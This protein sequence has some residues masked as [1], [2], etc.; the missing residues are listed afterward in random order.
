MRRKIVFLPYDMDT[1]LGINNEGALAFSYD[2]EDI[3]HTESGADIFNGQESVLWKNMRACYFDEMRSMYQ[4]L[5][6]TGALSY[7]RVEQMF[8]EH[9]EKWPEAVFNEDA[10]FKYL[11]PLVEKGNAAYL[12]MLQGSK[13]SQRRWWLYNRFRYIDS[14]YN[15]GDSL[16]D[17]IVIRGYAKADITVTPYA[18]VYASVKYG[19]YLI[20]ERAARNEATTLVCPLDNVNDTEIMIFSASQL[21]DV[22]DL[23]GLKVGYADF[24]RATRLQYLKLGDS[25]DEYTNGNLI[26][27]YL[28]NN[29]LLRTIDVR[30]CPALTQAV[31]LSGCSNIEH[32][33]FGG[34]SV[35]GL[36]LP[37]GGIL[38]TLQLPSTVT[39]L[40]ILNQPSLTS[41]SIG[42]YDNISTLRL[43]NVGSGV[44]TKTILMAL[45]ANSRVR[46]IDFAWE[47]ANTAEIESI[48]DK[49][50][51]MRGLDNNGN[52]VD[53]AQVY[54]TIH[55]SS[56]AGSDLDALSARYP[57]ITITADEVYA[58]LTYKTYDGS[59]IIATQTFTNGGNGTLVNSRL[60]DNSADGHYRYVPNGW[61]LTPDGSADEDALID[62]TAD[63]TVYAAY[64]AYVMLYTVTWVDYD[65][66]VL[67]TDT[68]VPWGTVP[69]YDGDIP[70]HENEIFKEWT[71]E[72]SAITG[73]TTYTASYVTKYTITFVTSSS[74]GGVTFQTLQV[75][76]GDTPVYTGETPT[77][78]RGGASEYEF[79]GWTPAITAATENATYTAL[80]RDIRSLTVK[81]LAKSLTEYNS[82]SNDTLASYGLYKQTNLVSV[83]VPATVINAN[84]FTDSNNIEEVD[85]TST[86]AIT[87]PASL[88]SGKTKLESLIIRSTTMSTL[89]NVNAFT[90][91]K[92][93]NIEG[94]IYV[95]SDLV[96]TYKA[97]T[98]WS[99]FVIAPIDSYPADISTLLPTTWE[100]INT[101][102][103]NGD[104]TSWP[105]GMTVPLT[106]GNYTLTMQLVAKDTD[107]L[108]DGSGNAHTTWI[109]KDVVCSSVMN[110]SSSDSYGYSSTPLYINTL[111]SLKA[112]IDS[113]VQGYMKS[114]KK[115]WRDNTSS[116]TITS[117]ETFWIPSCREMY[118]TGNYENTGCV[119]TSFFTNNNSRIKK[120]NGT[121]YAWWT[122]S[123]ENETRFYNVSNNGGPAIA[124]QAQ[125]H[126]VVPGFCI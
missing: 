95:P 85:F 41:F 97:N 20:Q 102:V 73:N 123:A 114:V 92:I 54:G 36:E 78:T 13:E 80:F 42:T 31:D 9:Q 44:N 8:S 125:T 62:I 25:S 83:V 50:D 17:Y 65:N 103:N 68:G 7:D 75:F 33:Y 60:R 61:S 124:Y 2:L 79:Y 99:N 119:Y 43:E 18:D 22:G 116:S 104:Y 34:T 1:A 3:D 101:G 110:S 39:N 96:D 115:T 86:E 93:A 46:L 11:A 32:V 113:V 64:T 112:N 84:A 82:T 66:T 53:T 14:K 51:T 70:S 23:S 24:S 26:E 67:E 100:E 16:S 111:P 57:D 74:D 76:E 63:R 55:V 109:S 89:A 72:V 120:L 121:A 12:G 106:S 58:V 5:R 52:N 126:G 98:N 87:I 88:F 81:Y 37:N 40:T 19:S 45:S 10:W 27:L 59:T 30:N 38:K 29:V 105:L 117:A 47:C 118:G 94:I 21:A 28:G 122:R 35:T 15:A 108:A 49:L 6:S 90:G 4:N 56:M 48:Y 77:T 91:T 107:E 71:P 69:T